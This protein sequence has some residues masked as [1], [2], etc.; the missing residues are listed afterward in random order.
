ML[1]VIDIGKT[2]MKVRTLASG[3]VIGLDLSAP[4]PV[5]RDGAYPH[6]DTDAIWDWLIQ[7]MG[8]AGSTSC[9][10][11][12]CVA[13][14]GAAAALIG[15][16]GKLNHG[17]LALPV[18]DYEWDGV[19]EFDAEYDEVRPSFDE[20]YSPSLPDGLN[21]GRQLYWQSK[22]FPAEFQSSLRIVPYA[23]YWSWRLSGV[24]ASEVSSLGCHTDLWAPTRK[25]WSSLAKRFGWQHRFAPVRPAWS[26]LGPLLPSVA[27][28]TGIPNS[29]RVLV[30]VHD[31]N[32][33]YSRFLWLEKATRP[34]VVSTGT[35]AISMCPDGTL[36]RLNEQR[37][38]LAN[39]DVTGESVACARFMG[40]REYA[41]ICA[42]TGAS[43]GADAGVDAVR[44]T[45]GENAFA[46]PDFSRGSGP[47]A[48]RR[49]EIIGRPSR[50]GAL[51]TLYLAMMIDHEL[52]LLESRG[53]IVIEGP[54]AEN[55][56]MCA[57]VAAL[58]P[59]QQV[60]RLEDAWGVAH[61]CLALAHWLD[62][63]REKPATIE[64]ARAEVGNLKSYRDE[65][66]RLSTG[67]AFVH[68]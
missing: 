4:T 45:I 24:A 48:A 44:A 32:A 59:D 7:S 18:L 13:T 21:L 9:I 49:G 6:F 56:T 31:S 33:S 43:P 22:R 67:K 38:M 54:F 66:R 40:G 17:G 35:W 30:G 19:R 64:C 36:D 41:E 39:V 55:K 60:M 2:N 8:R 27:E 68:A 51:A 52:D 37:D 3:G 11:K 53:R 46:L 57:L 10:K 28:A 25:S 47:F 20:S 42:L 61:G 1:L 12:I 14:H 65:W 34:T 16:G 5:R 15:A 23:Q 26:E 62:D 29:C 50:G 58:R 63:V